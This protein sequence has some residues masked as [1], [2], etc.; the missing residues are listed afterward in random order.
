M[1]VAELVPVGHLLR[2]SAI[3]RT[4]HWGEFSKPSASHFLLPLP[5]EL[6]TLHPL[7]SEISGF[8]GLTEFARTLIPAP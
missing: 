5:W 2:A 1:A 8:L 6:L 7:T 3:H 4:P